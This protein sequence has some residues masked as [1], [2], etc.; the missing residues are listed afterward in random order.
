MNLA[1]LIHRVLHNPQ[2]RLAF[3]TGSLNLDNTSL[4]QQEI[5][6]AREVLRLH[7]Q[8]ATAHDR[9]LLHILLSAPAG[10]RS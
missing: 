1:E 3:E 2:F 4:T 10:W 7:A 5:T 6:A 8:H 9:D